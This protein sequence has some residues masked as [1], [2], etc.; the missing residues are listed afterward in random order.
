MKTF[1]ELF[2]GPG[3]I[4]EEPEVILEE[5]TMNIAGNIIDVINKCIYPGTLNISGERIVD[6]IPGEKRYG[7]YI[8]P[9]FIDSHIHIESSML[10]PA[11]F[12]RIAVVHGTVASVSDPHEIANVLGIRGVRYMIENA[13]KS[14]FK[15]FF[16]APS[17]V[18][19]T[20][21][22]TS[23][24]TLDLDAVEGL[25]KRDDIKY[26][27]EVMNYP[28]VL[29]GEAGTMDKI[30]LAKK[31]H[32]RIDGH[33]PGLKDAVLAKYVK[34][35]IQTD[36]ETYEID[37]AFQKLKLGMKVQIREGS[38]AKDFDALHP[39]IDEYSD[40]CMFCS[41][42]MHP[43]D[44]VKGHI[45]VLVRRALSL[46]H[47]LMAVLRC[48]CVNPVKHYGLEVGLLRKGDFADF[49]IVDS[50]KDLSVLKTYING[51]KVAQQGKSLLPRIQPETINLF[52]ARKKYPEDFHVRAES[53][54]MNI[55]VAGDGQLITERFQDRPKVINGRAVSDTDR[56]ILK[57]AVI[58][59]YQDAH[60]AV[61]FVKNFGL[62]KGA[63]ATS[64]AHD[65]HNIVAVGV[66]DND[67]CDAVNAVIDNK[68]GIAV[69]HKGQVKSLALPI[70]GLMSDEDAY[71][72][73]GKYSRLEKFVENLGCT[74][75]APLLTLSFMALLVI[76]RLK[77]S[78][79]GLFDAEK[80]VFIN[81]FE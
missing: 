77:L 74:M 43:D 64:I 40:M 14:R 32:K 35:G 45:N 19:A 21:F 67:I 38:A 28:G 63:V 8:I 3:F 39:I 31:Y 42:D 25:L 5:Q 24:A 49:L 16:G 44:L 4:E 69:I 29:A 11:E 41:D 33:A 30:D 50:L 81:V 75:N 20:T 23:G 27:S 51:Q 34:A 10:T 53:D 72:V 78:D 68:G 59:R 46:G 70:A 12:A 71:A 9:G 17:C 57:M 52:N 56:D 36:H 37:E 62:K 60:P 61:C 18:P 58:N 48:A 13:S 1:S 6:I 7:T 80:F 15:F 76:P 66:S 65:S 2:E 79:K 54:V 47:D 73:A 55:I 22:E 26:L